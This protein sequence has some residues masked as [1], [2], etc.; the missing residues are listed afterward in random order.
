[1]TWRLLREASCSQLVESV[2]ID[3][4]VLS[5]ALAH[6]QHD[7]CTGKPT[8]AARHLHASFGS[9]SRAP[10]GVAQVPSGV[11]PH[12]T[13]DEK[14]LVRVPGEAAFV[15]KAGPLVRCSCLAAELTD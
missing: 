7:I 15:T 4:F 3:V 13:L 8:S 2:D 14:P 10:E 1:M 5:V 9:I 6:V 11:R 12:P